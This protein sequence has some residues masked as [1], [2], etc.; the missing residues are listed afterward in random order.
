MRV[1]VVGSGGREHALAW[2]ISRSPLLSALFVSPGNGG[3]VEIAENLPVKAEDIPGLVEAARQVRADLVVV[4][5]EA[6]IAR[7]IRDALEEAGIQAFAPYRRVSFLEA[8][9]IAAKHF[10]RRHGIP[11]A[12]AGTFE[13]YEEALA[14][15]GG[16][17]EGPVVIKADGLAG[18]KG[19]TIAASRT[20][21]EKVLHAY[22][23]ENRF[24]EASR[25]V[26][27]ETYLEGQ[28][29]SV[30]VASDGAQWA[31][32]GDARDY[33][34]LLD[35]DQGPNTGGM[36]SISPVPWLTEEMRGRIVEEIIEPTF[37]GLRQEG[38]RYE[39]ILY[40]G[41]IW[42]EEGPKVLEYNVRFGDP[43]TQV[44]VPRFA[45]DLLSL[46]QACTQGRLSEVEIRLS[47]VYAVGV[48][49]ASQGYPEKPQTGFEIS[50]LDRLKGA[51]DLYV[52]HAGTRRE[53]G[54]VVTVGGRVLTVVGTAPTLEGARR[55]AY[56]GITQ[57]RFQGMHYRRDIGAR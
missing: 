5:P 2:A 33:K 50:G 52:F 51:P 49:A 28:E 37:R 48:V 27:I 25:K 42:T 34:R 21:A 44:L 4:G 17:P 20:E 36:G 39:G 8:S 10:M 23:V 1:L 31:Y 47:E 57:I 7:G 11:T 41:L 6:P 38:L 9:K 15:L 30:F 53:N 46:A 26:V 3:T 24:G 18:G 40:F 54:R 13:R 35:G 16:L 55:R 29:L 45:F 56:E 14:Y 32:L 19:V 22:M 12:E 43:E